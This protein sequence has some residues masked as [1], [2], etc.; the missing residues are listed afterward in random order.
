MVC[1][2]KTI[3]QTMAD[4]PTILHYQH[5]EPSTVHLT[6]ASQCLSPNGKAEKYI[7]DLQYHTRVPVM[8]TIHK[9]PEAITL[10]LRPYTVRLGNKVQ[11][12]SP[13][14]SALIAFAAF[15]NTNKYVP[16]HIR[17]SSLCAYVLNTSQENDWQIGPSLC[18]ASNVHLIML[19]STGHNL[20]STSHL[21][22]NSIFF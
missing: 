4:F 3:M 6:L 18:H 12:H 22:R 10:H 9:W 20:N 19:S 5:Q 13:Q 17:I 1:M 11:N 7:R 2:Y 8:Q 16:S 14:K 21:M 15:A